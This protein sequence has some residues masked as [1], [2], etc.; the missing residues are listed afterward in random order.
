MENIIMVRKQL[1]SLTSTKNL[2]IP[3]WARARE[4]CGQQ[5][6][7]H[8]P[9]NLCH[10]FGQTNICLFGYTETV[11]QGRQSTKLDRDIVL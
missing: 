8:M 9:K 1:A 7:S 4:S 6:K 3:N 10:L 2:K 11:A 5:R